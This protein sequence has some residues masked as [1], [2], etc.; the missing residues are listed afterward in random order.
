MINFG[1]PAL[2]G[3]TASS[4]DVT[5]LERARSAQAI[6]DFEPRILPTTLR[7][8]RCSKPATS[9]T[10]TSSASR[11]TASSGRSRC[12]SSCWSGPR[13]DLETGKVRDR[14]SRAVAG[15][16]MD[17]R[18][19]QYYNLELQH[20]REM[21]AEFAA[22][23]SRRLPP[24]SGMNGL[25]VADPYVERL[26]EGVGFPGRARAAEARRRVPAL[27]AGAARDRL[28]ALPRADAVDAGRAAQAG[29]ERSEPGGGT[30]G[31]AR[32]H[33]A[34]AVGRRRRDR[35]RVPH[36]ARR[37][38]VA[39]RDRVGQLLLVR[40][41]SAAQRAADRAAHQGR[42]ADPAEDDRRPQVRADGDRSA[43]V[44]T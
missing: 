9:I 8:T 30:D 28:S 17:P 3:Q 20:L 19:L 27:H 43:A 12:R 29:P 37:H 4:L 18:L 14:R 10:T 25:E 7:V 5:D 11:F 40:A 32:Q 26:L 42:P 21:G 13:F 24:G 16:V 39:D 31:A 33:A 6:L 38:A 23:V 44:S 35:V 41:R 34:R 1:L 36:G 22:A 2:S 15:G